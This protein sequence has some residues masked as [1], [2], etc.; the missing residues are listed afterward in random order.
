MALN[1]GNQQAAQG[2]SKSIY[3]ALYDAL[4]STF[5][6]ETPTDDVCDSW[7]KMAYAISVGVIDHIKSNMA[8]K[9]V[10]TKGN[11][12]TAVKGNTKAASSHKHAVNI[13]AVADNVEF[14]QSN[15]GTGLVE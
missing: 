8:I 14:T 4:K 15:G 13:T 3:D 6:D 7:K 1:A 5:P 12:T 2:M 10:K 9:G 11:V